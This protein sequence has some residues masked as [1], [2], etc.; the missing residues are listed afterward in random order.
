[1]SRHLHEVADRRS[2]MLHRRVAERLI[3]DP[4]I[5]DRARVRVERWRQSGEVA[6]EYVTKWAH[7]L[8]QSIPNIASLLQALDD[9]AASLR[10]VSPFAG[11]LSARERWELLRQEKA[12]RD[13]EA[14]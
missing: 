13:H 10:Q 12:E 4:A 14:Q 1:M 2:L 3:Q 6:A 7:V 9:E 8:E 11:V 5:R